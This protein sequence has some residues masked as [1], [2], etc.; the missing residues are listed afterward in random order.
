MRFEETTIPGV[1]LI[2][3]ER[4]PDER[5][6]FVRT[7]AE[8]EFEAHGLAHMVARNLSYNRAHGTLRGM[9]FQRQPRAESKLVCALAGA[10]YDVAVDLRPDSPTY[11]RWIGTELRAETGAMLY[12]PEGCAHGFISLDP[13]T[14]IEYLI[15]AYYAPH[16]SGGVR[17]DDPQFGI[18]WPI[19]PTVISQ[20]DRN[21]PDFELSAI[22]VAS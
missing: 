21:W 13:E 1:L 17:W 3:P 2:T 22:G 16:A 5:G 20:R 10:I 19:Q 8:D 12:V 6:F 7:W 4:I 9:H 18:R 14:T 15:S 11:Q